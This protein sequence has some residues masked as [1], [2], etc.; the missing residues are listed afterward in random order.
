MV[1]SRG[2]LSPHKS[3]CKQYS[4]LMAYMLAYHQFQNCFLAH[5]F[6]I[7]Y[8]HMSSYMSM[9]SI[10]YIT[11]IICPD[12]SRS[13]YAIYIYLYLY[14]YIYIHI[15]EDRNIG[16]SQLPPSSTWRAR[17]AS[18]SR[19]CPVSK[20]RDS[21]VD[22]R[23]PEIFPAASGVFQAPIPFGVVTKT[24]ENENQEDE[25]QKN[26]G[27]FLWNIIWGWMWKR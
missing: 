26:G 14:I 27:C 17:L 16:I 20:V 7:D 3:A 25:P 4:M 24:H 1:V 11:D 21:T 18:M 5:G 10:R 8:V 2:H 12:N 9:C 22:T 15:Y 23:W 6:I 19:T 13:T